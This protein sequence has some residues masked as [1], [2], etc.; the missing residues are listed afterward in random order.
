MMR[1]VLLSI[2][3]VYCFL[4]AC[5]G[6]SNQ[7]QSPDYEATKKM[8]TDLM[9]SEDVKKAIVEI[10]AEDSAQ[11]LYVIHDDTVRTAIEEALTSE[12]GKEFWTKMFTDHEFVKT[13]SE[14][15]ISQQ[16]D[17]FKRLMADSAYQEKMLELFENPDFGKLIQSQLKNQQFKSHLEESI[18]QTLESPLFQ[19]TVAEIVVQH[20]KK[21]VAE[22]SG[23]S[24]GE[25]GQGS[26]SSES[27][28][29]SGS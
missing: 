22:E 18:Q 12:K 26:E 19:A 16:E 28:G 3:I 21:I 1:Q 9:K 20:A 6:N 15:M 13:F 17:V 24:E 14:A 10:I 29:E 7:S 2:L 27:S 25:S 11:Q 8:V 4:T 23:G 5:S